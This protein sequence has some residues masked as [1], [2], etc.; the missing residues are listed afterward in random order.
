MGGRGLQW[1]ESSGCGRVRREGVVEGKDSASQLLAFS[2]G[3]EQAAGVWEMCLVPGWPQLRSG[4]PF[5]MGSYKTGR[6]PNHIH[7]TLRWGMRRVSRATTGISG[8]LW[9]WAWEAQSSPRVVRES[10]GLRNGRGPHLEG[11]QEHQASSL[12]LTPTLRLQGPCRV[13]TGE[14][15]LVLSEEGNPAGLSSC[16][17]G[18]RPLVELPGEQSRDLSPNERGGWTPLRPLRGL[19]E[20]RVATRE[21][22][23]EAAQTPASAISKRGLGRDARPGCIA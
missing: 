3:K 13:G 7:T 23:G 20:I 18:L 4:L 1:K 2:P 17:G 6:A 8:F 10:W 16:S 11:R 14:S 5:G 12:F 9:G 15:G 19:Q 22:I 21:D